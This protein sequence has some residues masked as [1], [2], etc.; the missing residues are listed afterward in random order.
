MKK[1]INVVNNKSWA[2]GS[3]VKHMSNMC[4]TY[5]KHIKT[6]IVLISV[7]FL[8]GV[9]EKQISQADQKPNGLELGT[10]SPGHRWRG[11]QRT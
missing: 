10:V 11:P 3:H 6:S 5:V 7:I 1:K 2:D 8:W 4:K 9:E